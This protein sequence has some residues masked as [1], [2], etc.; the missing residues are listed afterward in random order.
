MA[1]R[2]RI[3]SWLQANA[4]IR[5]NGRDA[6]EGQPG[7]YVLLDREW[8]QGDTVSLALPMAWNWMIMG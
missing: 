2:I 6:A 7:S 1:L 3:P 8:T 4:V 5:V